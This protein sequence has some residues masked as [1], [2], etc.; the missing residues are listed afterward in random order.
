MQCA[1][2]TPLLDVCSQTWPDK[3]AADQ[4]GGGPRACMGEMVHVLEDQPAVAAWYQR[5]DAA[6]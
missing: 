6:C 5:L 2:P 3:V 4:P 1:F